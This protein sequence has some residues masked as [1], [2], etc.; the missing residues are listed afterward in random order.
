MALF[1]EGCRHACVIVACQ[2]SEGWPAYRHIYDFGSHVHIKV[3]KQRWLVHAAAHFKCETVKRQPCHTDWQQLPLG[4]THSE[5]TREASKLVGRQRN[6]PNPS[7]PI[8][9]QI[10]TTLKLHI[11]LLPSTTDNTH[12]VHMRRTKQLRTVKVKHLWN[13]SS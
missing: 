8:C 9:I 4:M 11:S 7:L 6:M 2:K 10:A 1:Q 3:Y 13:D 5:T 12:N